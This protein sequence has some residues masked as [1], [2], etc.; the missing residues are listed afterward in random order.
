MGAPLFDLRRREFITLLGGAVAWPLA[1]RA[2]QPERM[3]R[4]GV[5]MGMAEKDPKGS[6]RAGVRTRPAGAG[7]WTR[8]LRIDYRLAPVRRRIRTAVAEL[9]AMAPDLILAQGTAMTAALRNRARRANRVH[10]GVRPCWPRPRAE[11][12]ASGRQSHRLHQFR[13]L[14][15]RKW[16][17]LLKQTAP[18][19]RGSRSSSIRNWPFARHVSCGRPRR[20][21][22]PFGDAIRPVRATAD[23]DRVFDALARAK[24]GSDSGVGPA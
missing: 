20:L 5:L 17:H 7:R 10:A 23:L 1:A 2:Q 15:G 13:A 8:N 24:R 4:I 11:P 21:P 9:F 14:V 6:Q 12:G 16:L 19:S 22:P 18:T 3:R